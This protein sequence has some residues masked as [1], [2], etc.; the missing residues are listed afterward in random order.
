MKKEQVLIKRCDKYDVG[1]IQALIAAGMETFGAKPKGRV[2]VKPNIV[3]AHH[4]EN[5][6]GT[7]MYTSKSVVEAAVRHLHDAPGVDRVEIGEKTAIGAPTRLMYKFSG[8]RK[9]VQS[10]R[11]EGLKNLTLFAL[12]EDRRKTV[13][14]GGVV[15]S[16][17]RLSRRMLKS[18][19]R[20]YLAK[21]KR[22]GS[23]QVTGAT[24]LNIGIL[25]DDER[26]VGHDYRLPEKIVDLLNVG[27]PDFIVM[28]AID[29]G[30]GLEGVPHQRNLGLLIMGTNPLAV[31]IVGAYLYGFAPS[32]VD[33]L[34]A[35][36][37]RGFHPSGLDDIEL[38][39]DVTSAAELDALRS[40][41]K[42][43]D[44]AWDE[45][46]DV[47][48][49][50]KAIGAPIRFHLGPAIREAKTGRVFHCPSGCAM[51]V[52]MSLAMLHRHN[53]GAM[54]ACKP[55]KVIVGKHD[56]PIDCEGA[57]AL[58]LGTCTEAILENVG[59]KIEIRRCFTTSSDNLIPFGLL[60]G[61]PNP[62]LKARFFG[63]LL[64]SILAAVTI[65]TFNGH[66][67]LEIGSFIATKLQ[68]EL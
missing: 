46:Q 32:D 58:V 66:Y 61:I 22:H 44:D 5:C 68:K 7:T 6:Y 29:A 12:D 62:M 3:F 2:F 43:G 23:C 33:Y 42:P 51:G 31:D 64:V 47:N 57:S 15:H 67:L 26:A 9:M 14:V 60:L 11:S 38:I 21:L 34:A 45:W 35:A 37:S 8:Y 13:Y 28:D 18:D 48:E 10:L 55:L 40:R 50:A 17:L 56:Q 24:K 49:T 52:K 16:T 19:F 53:K 39:G 59:R 41:L 36:I 63:N 4:D 54:A 27:Y 25:S 20:I 65:K 1:T 30:V